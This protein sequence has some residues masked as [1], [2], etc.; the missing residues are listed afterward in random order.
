MSH[1]QSPTE[2]RITEIFNQLSINQQRF[3]TARLETDTDQEAAEKIGLAR[4]TVSKWPER[5]L[6]REALTI[7]AT[8]ANSA[9]WAILKRNAIKAAMVKTKGLDSPDEKIAQQVARE[10]LEHI[11]D[12]PEQPINVRDDI[13]DDQRIARITAILDAA[14]TRRGGQPDSGDSA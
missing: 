7:A 10:I 5:E 9:V 13:T 2:S 8:D 6:I 12:L 1:K 14:R 4:E 11:I 3:V